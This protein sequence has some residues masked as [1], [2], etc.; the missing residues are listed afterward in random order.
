MSINEASMEE[1]PSVDVTAKP[2]IDTDNLY[3]PSVNYTN[4]KSPSVNENQLM[5]QPS[6]ASAD[7]SLMYF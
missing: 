1:L 5:H 4:Q 3:Q 2:S 7:V 6:T